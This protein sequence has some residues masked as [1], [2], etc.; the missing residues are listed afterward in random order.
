[1][2]GLA[3]LFFIGLYV[4]I[5]YKIVKR[6]E[7]S[8]YKWL[9]LALMVLIPSGDAVVGRLYLKHL[10]MEEGGL[11]VHRVAEHVEGFMDDYRDYWVKEGK[12]QF[13]EEFPVNGKVTRHFKQNG[14]MIREDKEMPQSK[15]RVRSQTVGSVHDRYLRDM[16]LVESISNSEIL[17]SDTQI[18]F[19]GGWAERFL[20]QFS[21]AGGGAVAWCTNTEL[22]PVIRHRRIVS[23]T[24]KPQGE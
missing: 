20:A 15:Y 23:N 21:D 10:C 11:K 9:V 14:Q 12:Y 17:A 19:N 6:F 18:A 5:T 1:M 8:R 4:F 3:A 22:D 16:F 13:S 2:G 24:L 7:G